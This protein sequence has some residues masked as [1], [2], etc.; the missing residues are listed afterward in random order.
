M[1][2]GRGTPVVGKLVLARP[3]PS[4]RRAIASLSGC[5]AVDTQSVTVDLDALNAIATR[6]GHFTSLAEFIEAVHGRPIRAETVH[7]NQLRR[8]WDELWQ[9]AIARPCGGSEVKRWL[10]Q[11]RIKTWIRRLAGED[12][13]QCRLLLAHLFAVLERLPLQVPMPLT[14]LAAE[15]CGDSHAL[16]RDSSLGRLTAR[17]LAALQRRPPAHSAAEIRILWADVGIVLD[18]LSATVLVLNLPA[19]PGSALGDV[20]YRMR[21]A[22]DPVRLTFRQLR[23]NA[24]CEFDVA[25]AAEVFVCENPA[26]VAAAA[27][28]WGANCRP[29]VCVEGQP[30]LAAERLLHMLVAR[31]VSLHYHGDFDWGGIRIAAHLWK[32]FRFTPWRFTRDDYVQAPPGRTLSGPQIATP[33]DDRLAPA[34]QAGAVVVHEEAVM[35]HLIADLRPVSSVAA[36]LKSC[37]TPAARSSRD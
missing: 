27:D 12:L 17:A 7:R 29:L 18:E 4:E 24:L 25:G 16:D 21:Q 32:R 23:S 34:M 30:N 19:L 33:W 3:S 2:I 1:W 8:S 31:D 11:S 9:S 6:E 26:V 35:E 10:A 36:G 20:L 14:Q 22:G 13:E 5:P 28:R 15:M 37:G